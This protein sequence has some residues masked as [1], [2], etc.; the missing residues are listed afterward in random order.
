MVALHLGI[1]DGDS[2]IIFRHLLAMGAADARAIVGGG[3]G[4]GPKRR[5]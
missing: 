5:K 4:N 2:E 1:E 3:A